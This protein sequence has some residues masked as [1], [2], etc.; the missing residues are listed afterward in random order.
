MGQ[1]GE[2]DARQLEKR[3]IGVWD[4]GEK[5]CELPKALDE[6]ANAVVPWRAEQIIDAIFG[7]IEEW[8]TLRGNFGLNERS[9]V[10]AAHK[11]TTVRLYSYVFDHD[12]GF[13]PNPFHGVCTL[14]TCKPSIREHA[15]S[16]TM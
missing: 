6:Y 9:H 13:A 12:Y 8:R 3:I 5:D 14:A 2:R 16:A 15:E 1:L 7:S 4:H 10:I 11:C